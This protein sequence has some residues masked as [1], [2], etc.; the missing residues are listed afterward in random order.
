MKRKGGL[1]PRSTSAQEG[2][3]GGYFYLA[4]RGYLD[5]P[6]RELTSMGGT[7]RPLREK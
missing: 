2:Q 5:G 1:L 4:R 7:D 6:K 3:D